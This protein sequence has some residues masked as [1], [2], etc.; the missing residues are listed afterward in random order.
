MRTEMS[1]ETMDYR[2]LVETEKDDVKKTV[3]YLIDGDYKAITIVKADNG[4]IITAIMN[5]P[6]QQIFE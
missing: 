3:S 6:Q 4:Y 1:T 5:P 2:I